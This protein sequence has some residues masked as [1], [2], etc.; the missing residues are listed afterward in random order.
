[1][2]FRSW[3]GTGEVFRPDRGYFQQSN[4]GHTRYDA[5]G[6]MDLNQQPGGFS[7]SPVIIPAMNDLLWAEAKLRMGD[8]AGASSLI[9]NTR[10]GRGNLP[11]SAAVVATPGSPADGPCMSNGKLAKDGTPCTL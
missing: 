10:V 3:S 2:L 5:S 7:F 6:D 11:S 9:D 1:M 4:I 8:A